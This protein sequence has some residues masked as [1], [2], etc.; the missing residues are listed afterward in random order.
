MGTEIEREFT[1][2]AKKA[3]LSDEE[4][5]NAFNSNMIKGGMLH[6]GK[7]IESSCKSATTGFDKTDVFKGPAE[8]S[9]DVQRR[10]LV[11]ADGYEAGDV[12]LHNAFAVGGGSVLEALLSNDHRSML[13]P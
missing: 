5:K 13:P 4:T 8:F 12:V 7:Q 11:A 3:G 2:K 10:W 6:N 9:R 1:E